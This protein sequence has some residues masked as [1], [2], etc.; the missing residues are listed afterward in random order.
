[1]NARIVGRDKRTVTIEVKI[2]LDEESMLS[3]EQAILAAVNEAG[4][5]ASGEALKK[6]DTAGEPILV[7]G[8]RMTSK[9][10]SPLEYQ[11]PFGT[12]VVERH[13]Y[14][15]SRGG[16]TYCPM[17]VGARTLIRSTPRFAM[18]LSHKYAVMGARQVMLDLKGNHGRST[19]SCFVQ[20]ISDAVGSVALAT[21]Q[22]WE[23]DTPELSTRVHSVTVGI[24]GA[25]M[26]MNGEWRQAMCGTIALYDKDGNRLHTTYF[27]A[28]PEYGQ[29]RFT[30][31][32]ER[33]VRLVRSRNSKALFI[34]LADGAP[35]NWE[36]LEKHT[37][38]QILDFYHA[39]G[40]LTKAADVV[41]K[42]DADAHKEWLDNACHRLKHELGAPQ[43]LIRELAR[44]KNLKELSAADR[45][46]VGTAA[47]YFRKN[48]P[49]MPYARHTRAG[50]SIG[51]GVTE[52][53]CKVIIKERMCCSGMRKWKDE[54]ARVVIALRCL[55]KT[56]GHWDQFWQH[57]NRD[58]YSVAEIR[59]S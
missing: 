59:T 36:F 43:Q 27:G 32:L 44:F 10:L 24:D 53:A 19:S 4:A 16:E 50:L 23:Y 17:D 21:E 51:S 35:S 20:N 30:D 26:P 52:A 1:M 12:V 3:S 5:L 11:C 42:K 13:I 25:M 54:G 57:I 6:F 38:V 15:D 7:G 37:D 2:A 55:T 31:R 28:A 39:T 41:F 8:V 45:D 58:G 46:I 49:R 22:S 40:Y 56:D 29:S 47:S 9:G 18:I 33:E 34:G 14:Q 48:K